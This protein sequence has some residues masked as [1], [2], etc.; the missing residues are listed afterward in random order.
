MRPFNYSMPFAFDKS[1][2]QYTPD[3]HLRVEITNISKANVCPYIGREIPNYKELGLK[4][5][6][7]YK[8]YRDPDELKKAAASK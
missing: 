4:A 1:V 8:L 7:I 5:D 6:E 3:G 2:R